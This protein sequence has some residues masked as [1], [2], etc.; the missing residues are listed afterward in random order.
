MT[1]FTVRA[2]VPEDLEDLYRVYILADNLHQQAHPDIFRQTDDSENIKDFL[3]A[4]IGSPYSVIFV[5]K[6][7]NEIIGVVIAFIRHTKD[8][9]ILVQRPYL[10]VDNLVVVEKYRRKGVGRALMQSVHHWAKQQGIDQIQ[11]TVWDF[12]ERAQEFYE[13]L[14]Y[15]MLH[16]RMRKVLS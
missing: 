1:E 8:I 11:L 10:S 15:K 12:N 14:G 5:G 13:K 16:H 2:A 4:E 3:R 7:H 9:D 6:A